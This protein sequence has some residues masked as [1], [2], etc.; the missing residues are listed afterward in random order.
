M[1]VHVDCAHDPNYARA[2]V[3]N[4]ENEVCI[5]TLLILSMDAVSW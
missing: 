5:P 4:L 3:T 1:Y 2:Y